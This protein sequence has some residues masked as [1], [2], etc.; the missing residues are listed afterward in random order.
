M[1]E[2]VDLAGPGVF[3]IVPK[4]DAR[5]PFDADASMVIFTLNGVTYLAF[6]D[7]SDGYRS[8]CGKLLSFEGSVYE[9]GTGEW[10]PTYIREDVLCSHRS[11]GSYG[12]DDVLEVRSKETGGVI[13]EIGTTSVDDYYPSSTCRWAPENLSQNAKARAHD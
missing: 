2:L 10:Y 1:S 9:M 11:K 7:P 12:E 3:E 8:H 4:L 6:E 5:H 13:F